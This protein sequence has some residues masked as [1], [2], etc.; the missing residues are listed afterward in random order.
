MTEFA[1]EINFELI[2][3]HILEVRMGQIDPHLVLGR[4]CTCLYIFYAFLRV[5]PEYSAIDLK[6]LKTIIMSNT[7]LANPSYDHT[8]CHACV[9]IEL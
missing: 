1:F 5:L 4:S 6:M 2:E 9:L 3:A 8:P 7:I